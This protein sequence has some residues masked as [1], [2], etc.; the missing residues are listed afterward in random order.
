MLDR[1]SKPAADARPK[2]GLGKQILFS[3]IIVCALLSVLEGTI[4]LWA[5]YFRT[6]YERYNWSTGRLELVPGVRYTTPSGHEFRINSRGFVGPEFDERPSPGVYRIIAVG[7]SCT[8]AT[9]LWSIGY[10]SILEASLNSTSASR[11]FEVINAGI[12]LAALLISIYGY[13]ELPERLPTHISWRGVIDG[14]VPKNFHTMFGGLML[15]VGPGPPL[16]MTFPLP[17]E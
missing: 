14:W 16:I 8:F 15:L 1:P 11:R 6:S 17:R 9:G 4:R 10:P 2:L 7:D 12:F 3:T 5:F 13:A